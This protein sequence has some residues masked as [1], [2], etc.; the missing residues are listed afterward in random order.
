MSNNPQWSSFQSNIFNSSSDTSLLRSYKP[1]SIPSKNVSPAGSHFSMQSNN[2]PS[3]NFQ[4]SQVKRPT[5]LFNNPENSFS[6]SKFDSLSYDKSPI[7]NFP[8]IGVFGAE[9]FNDKANSSSMNSNRNHYNMQAG[10]T[11]NNQG[12][13]ETGIIEKLLVS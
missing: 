8:P 10:D 13:R 9:L 6:A 4:T 2:M 11:S 3:Y 5:G 7:G 12:T 1:L